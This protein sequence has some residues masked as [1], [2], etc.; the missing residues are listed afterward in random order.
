MTVPGTTTAA[1]TAP[2]AKSGLPTAADGSNL[3]ACANGNCEVQVDGPTTI[4]VPGMPL[5]GGKVQIQQ[6]SSMAVTAAASVFGFPA[7]S[8][9]PS[10]GTMFLNGLTIKVVAVQGSSA[11]LRLST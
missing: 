6:I 11:V 7:S 8:T 10:G 4:P 3:G 5:I 9:A 2:K 1:A